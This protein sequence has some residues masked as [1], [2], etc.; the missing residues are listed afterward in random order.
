MLCAGSVFAA[1]RAVIKPLIETGWQMDS[2][3]HKSQTNEKEVFTYFVKP[4][5]NLGYTTDKSLISLDYYARIW[6]YDDQDDIVIT[7]GDKHADDYDYTEHRAMFTAQ[8]QATERLLLGIDNLFWKSSDPANADELSN[9]VDRYRYTMNQLTPRLSYRFGEKFGVDLKYRN[10]NTDYSNDTTSEDYMENRGVFTFNYFFT[11]KTSFNLDYQYWQTDY[12]KTTVD[13]E[14]NQIMANVKHQFN[15]ITLGAGAGYHDRDFDGTVRAGDIE[16]FVWKVNVMGQTPS[17]V[18]SIPRSSI[19]FQVG[20]NL[21]D[22]GSGDS[23]YTST[24]FDA[25]LSYFFFDRI[26]VIASG[27]FQNSDY[28]TSPTDREDDRW[29]GDLTLD[30]VFNEYFTLGVKGGLEERDSSD[31]GKDFDNEFVMV[32]VKFNYNLGAK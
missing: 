11:P 13:Y 18:G 16:Q 1:G 6:R 24:R 31:A 4:G 15:K 12:D 30:Y 19:F 23:Y 26:N 27:Y 2:N 8:T 25:R 9:A 28:E 14:S 10:L 7:N 3:F 17:K 21:N 20:S 22:A 5:L 32:N 29:Y